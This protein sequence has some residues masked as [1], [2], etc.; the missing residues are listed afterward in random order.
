MLRSDSF[1]DGETPAVAMDSKAPHRGRPR[2]GS[3]QLYRLIELFGGNAKSR[4]GR[5]TQTRE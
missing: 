1:I 2:V 4:A 5:V 3:R